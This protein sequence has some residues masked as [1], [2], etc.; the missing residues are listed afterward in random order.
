M[1]IGRIDTAVGGNAV[2]EEGA[3]V[4][5]AVLDEIPKTVPGLHRRLCGEVSV[6]RVVK[7]AVEG[8]ELSRCGTEEESVAA[9]DR[10]GVEEHQAFLHCAAGAVQARDVSR[11]VVIGVVKIGEI[12]EPAPAV[13]AG[14]TEN[15]RG[16]IVQELV[17]VIHAECHTACGVKPAVPHAQHQ[18]GFDGGQ[19][20][21]ARPFIVGDIIAVHQ[22][23][24]G[25]IVL[26]IIDK[27]VAEAVDAA[28]HPRKAQIV[29]FPYAE[30]FL[31]GRHGSEFPVRRLGGVVD[32]GKEEIL[33][34]FSFGMR[35]ISRG[36]E[37]IEA[38][39]GVNDVV[40]ILQIDLEIMAQLIFVI[41]LCPEVIQQCFRQIRICYGAEF[42]AVI[43]LQ[44][45]CLAVDGVKVPAAFIGQQRV[46][47]QQIILIIDGVGVAVLADEREGSLSLD[48]IIADLGLNA[49]GV[50]KQKF[51]VGIEQRLGV[52]DDDGLA[53][54]R[55]ARG[56]AVG[57][58]RD[59]FAAV[60]VSIPVA[61]GIVAVEVRAVEHQRVFFQ[62]ALHADKGG[63]DRLAQAQV[64]V[65]ARDAKVLQL[66]GFPDAG[67]QLGTGLHGVVRAR[68]SLLTGIQRGEHGVGA[69]RGGGRHGGARH[70]LV[71][72]VDV[73]FGVGL[74]NADGVDIKNDV[75]ASGRTDEQTDAA[76]PVTELL[77]ARQTV[78]HTL[79]LGH[80]YTDAL[81]AAPVD[82]ARGAAAVDLAAAVRFLDDLAAREGG[83]RIA[84][85][86][87][88]RDVKGE[89][90]VFAAGRFG[91]LII[92]E[93]KGVPFIRLGIADV[94]LQR[95]G[96]FGFGEKLVLADGELAGGLG[97]ARVG[98]T[99]THDA[100]HRRAERLHLF[101]AARQ[102]GRDPA[103]ADNGVLVKKTVVFGRLIA[104]IFIVD[105]R[106]EAGVADGR[107]HVG[108]RREHIDAASADVAEARQAA[109]E[110]RCADGDQ[111]GRAA[112]RGSPLQM[113]EIA[114]IVARGGKGDDAFLA[115]TVDD[116]VKDVA[117][118]GRAPGIAGG[119][120]VDAALLRLQRVVECAQLAVRI[121]IVGFGVS[122][123]GGKHHDLHVRLG[124]DAGN[125]HLVV[126]LRGDHAGAVGA[127]TDGIGDVLAVVGK[128]KA[129]LTLK[130]DVAGI[131][132]Q[133]LRK[134]FVVGVDARVDEGDNG[135]ILVAAELVP[136]VSRIDGKILSL[137]SAPVTDVVARRVGVE[138]SVGLVVV[139]VQR[140]VQGILVAFRLG[141]IVGLRRV[142]I[143]VG[144]QFFDH[145]LRVV[146]R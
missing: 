36:H 62:I 89:I 111:I 42:I 140:V 48:Q 33:L 50:R 130:P 30:R 12:A 18:L 123:G 85:A 45:A 66:V 10:G 59:D 117:F 11:L 105:I 134:V 24:K 9:A 115:Q 8:F 108:A 91:V 35:H 7:V 84:V 5:V 100:E 139:T 20:R 144:G 55:S 93:V 81:V 88:A 47:R 120:D 37:L 86:V 133:H 69:R 90:G 3:L 49:R 56:H 19:S 17:V 121:H 102:R 87:A 51:G 124:G 136:G 43:P 63:R 25:A 79:C 27:L 76:C 44:L 142:H 80:M 116:R 28:V 101:A 109:V 129:V 128:V 132:P 143:R 113:V 96:S 39:A 4:T 46:V 2:E 83:V 95:A 54:V 145:F 58:Q 61:E 82:V 112:A 119:D 40:G 74:G 72:I 141:Q 135:F 125:A 98:F 71:G 94:Q 53:V 68:L 126:R 21:L 104:L 78:A 22:G 137:L 52:L 131:R 127:V 138:R 118:A 65:A 70:H 29:E 122:R 103:V 15:L 1:V 67:H 41:P 57:G 114:V 97:L 146:D 107:E 60:A 6:D 31:K 92:G 73:Y 77:G 14:E 38:V 32:G 23:N 26:V 110:L 106:E 34:V 16:Q 64:D 99:V 13:A 75:S